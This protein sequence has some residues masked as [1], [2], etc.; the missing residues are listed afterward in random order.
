[1][2]TTVEYFV[3]SC[4]DLI[5][6]SAISEIELRLSF[7]VFFTSSASLKKTFCYPFILSSIF[8]KTLLLIKVF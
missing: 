2:N 7:T 3:K 6:L 8:F 4:A 5:W 1:M